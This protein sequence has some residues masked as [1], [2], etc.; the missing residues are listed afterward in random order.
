[1]QFSNT[2]CAG[3]TLGDVAPVHPVAGLCLAGAHHACCGEELGMGF[4]NGL[5]LRLR[6]QLRTSV[7]AHDLS[8]AAKTYHQGQLCDGSGDA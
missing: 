2:A 8:D 5:P 1:M 3:S 7:A 6:L 4:A